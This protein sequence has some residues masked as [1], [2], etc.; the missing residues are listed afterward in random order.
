MCLNITRDRLYFCDRW[1]NYAGWAS[2]G[3]GHD[4]RMMIRPLV[5]CVACLS[6]SLIN[7]REWPVLL[8]VYFNSNRI[9]GLLLASAIPSSSSVE[10]EEL[11]RERDSLMKI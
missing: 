1:V 3:P 2:A 10:E 4:G 6:V 9:V 5:L 8:L 7:Q 11:D